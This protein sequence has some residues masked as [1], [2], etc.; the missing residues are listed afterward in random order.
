M[1]DTVD[2]SRK[3]TPPTHTRRKI[4]MESK[5]QK[6]LLTLALLVGFAA[7]AARAEATLSKVTA[8]QR[9]GTKLVV[10]SYDVASTLGDAVVV[11]LAVADGGESIPCP[12]VSG[13]IGLNLTAGSGKELVWDMGA[14][15]DGHVSD[16]LQFT[17]TAVER[18]NYLVIDLSGGATAESYPFRYMDTL[19]SPLPDDYKTTKLVLRRIPTGTFVMGSPETELGRDA[20]ETPHEVNL[21]Q[22]Y[23]MGVFEVTQSQWTLVMGSNPS[24]HPLGDKHPVE[25]VHY[26]DIRGASAG[27]GWPTTTAVDAGSFIGKLQSKTGLHLDLPTEARWEYACRAGTTL[28]YNDQ[29]KNAGQGSHCLI[30]KES[31]PEADQNLDPLAIYAFSIPSGHAEVGTKQPNAWGLYDTLGNVWELCLDWEGTYALSTVTDPAGPASGT[32]RITRGGGS[33]VQAPMC[34]SAER[35]SVNPSAFAWESDGFRLCSEIPVLVDATG[36]HSDQAV[37]VGSADSRNYVLT[38]SSLHGA[39]QPE[40]GSRIYCWHSTLVCSVNNSAV[41]NGVTYNS[42]GWNGEGSIPAVGTASH[43]ETITLGEL[44]SSISWQWEVPPGDVDHDGLN[45]HW[46]YLH[47]QTLNVEPDNDPDRD[48]RT[49]AEEEADGTDPNDPASTLGLTAYYPLDGHSMDATGNGHDGT[50]S[51][52][53]FGPGYYP[54]DAVWLDGLDD[55]VALNFAAYT[56]DTATTDYTFSMWLKPQSGDTARCFGFSFGGGS[57]SGSPGISW[58]QGGRTVQFSMAAHDT[59]ATATLAGDAWVHVTGVCERAAGTLRLYVDGV[60]AGQGSLNGP[61]SGQV[62]AASIGMGPDGAGFGGKIGEVRFYE[63]ALAAAEVDRLYT[64]TGPNAPPMGAI[65]NLSVQQRPGTKIVDIAYDLHSADGAPVE[66]DF[67]L[68]DMPSGHQIP[69]SA[70]SG[71]IGAGIEPG[72]RKVIVWNMAA[73]W[74]ENAATLKFALT[75][76]HSAEQNVDLS[77]VMFSSLDD[78][79]IKHTYANGDVTMLDTR[80]NLMWTHNADPYGSVDWH[81]AESYCENLVY[82]GYSD[83]HLPYSNFR[84]AENIYSL[85]G[86]VLDYHLFANN[87]CTSYWLGGGSGWYRIFFTMESGMLSFRWIEYWIGA[88]HV[89]PVRQWLTDDTWADADIVEAEARVDSRTYTLL[90]QSEVGSPTPHVGRNLTFCWKSTVDCSVNAVSE[91]DGEAYTCSG[92]IGTGSVPAFGDANATGPIVLDSLFSSIAWNWKKNIAYVRAGS[93]GDGSSWNNA[94]GDLQAAINSSSAG[95]EVWVA[96][97]TYRPNDSDPQNPATDQHFMLRDRVRLYGGFAGTEVE[98]SQRDPARHPTVLSG[99]LSGNDADL[100]GDG[101]IDANTMAD[102]AV[103]IIDN[104]AEDGGL[105]GVILDGL[106]LRGGASRAIY[107]ERVNLSVANCIFISN[108]SG[109]YIHGGTLDA[110]N[111]QFTANRA[112]GIYGPLYAEFSPIP[113]RGYEYCGT[114]VNARN[115]TFAD[116]MDHGIRMDGTANKSTPYYG[117]AN[118]DECLFSDN[119]GGGITILW[120]YTTVNDSHFLRNGC[121]V[122]CFDP[123]G[124][125]SIAVNRSLFTENGAGINSIESNLSVRDSTFAANSTGISCREEWFYVG[126]SI[127]YCTFTGHTGWPFTH[128]NRH[129]G[130]ASG[131]ISHSIIWGNAGGAIDCSNENIRVSDSIIEGGFAAGTNIQNVDPRLLPLADNGGLFPS[132]ALQGGSPAINR[133]QQ[134]GEMW[135]QRRFPRDGLADY[136]A[137]EFGPLYHKLSTVVTGGGVVDCE[138][139]WYA[140]GSNVVITATPNAGYYFK[141]WSGDISGCTAVGNKLSVPVTRSREITLS[142]AK[143]FSFEQWLS[144]QS[145]GGNPV[146]LFAQDRNG[147]GV[148]NGIEYAFG[149]NWQPGESLQQ[150]RFVNGRPVFEI[151]EQDAATL[152]YVGLRVLGSTNLIDWTLPV[153]QVTGAAPGSVWYQL[154]G[155][156]TKK[157][158]FKLEAVTK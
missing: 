21:K 46:E 27:A 89:W 79:W 74:E 80:A 124:G 41:E 129:Y 10:I 7:P 103:H 81:S 20:D 8:A 113:G 156:P 56:M 84:W 102:N 105:S 157:A 96:E 50:L 114:T 155:P 40:V 133:V 118:V 78:R 44:V 33:N 42:I 116:N 52:A 73:D 49:N 143:G 11:S 92:W 34:R 152:P 141:E 112:Y 26:Q 24:M 147:D 83:W 71:D 146:V 14:D 86:F 138:D 38:V 64:Q 29:T 23:Y 22:D 31:G 37:L 36:E 145:T 150:I 104:R 101:F 32:R 135:D 69:V 88:S 87:T 119:L 25:K 128:L 58:D 98:R 148:P 30:G 59:P 35:A 55:S 85:D 109:I 4:P 1:L 137:Y 66:I 126:I 134:A 106:V 65:S 68:L 28:A 151:P 127:D 54:D 70:L 107:L 111:C 53:V 144:E 140:S 9:P 108:G 154:D 130:S 121:G 77:A 132:V 158:F 110:D 3:P 142:F 75:A 95:G 6:S 5:I 43:T 45:D 2:V 149:A 60:L 19:P 120:A 115:S 94:T 123:A 62:A 67:A 18:T 93:N 61:V 16:N 72:L 13:D 17:L 100:D 63:R 122:N 39:P 15:W 139:G 82:A 99:D 125:Y 47:F 90:V 97:G 51:G 136:G 12:S 153:I 131:S 48:G 91:K 117:I 57:S 76:K